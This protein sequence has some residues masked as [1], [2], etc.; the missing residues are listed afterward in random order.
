M[1]IHVDEQEATHAKYWEP[2]QIELGENLTECIRHYLMR[3]GSI[4][5]QGDVYFTLKDRVG[6][7][8]A[9]QALKDI[10]TFAGY[11]EKFLTPENEP[12]VQLRNALARLKRLEVTTA[13]PFLLNCY[14][15]YAHKRIGRKASNAATSLI[16]QSEH[17]VRPL[18]RDGQGRSARPYAPPFMRR[19]LS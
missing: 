14:H 17:G 11:Y 1:R 5:K 9:L 8:D 16:F 15:D 19:V 4:A 3:N 12:D 6:Q 18:L 7:S 2:M 10:A 13:Y